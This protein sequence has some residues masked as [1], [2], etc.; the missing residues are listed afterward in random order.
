M[1]IIVRQVQRAGSFKAWTVFVVVNDKLTI[2]ITTFGSRKAFALVH[3]LLAS[4]SV[5]Q[6]IYIKWKEVNKYFEPKKEIYERS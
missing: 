4:G 2:T 1:K 5:E 3:A 6:F